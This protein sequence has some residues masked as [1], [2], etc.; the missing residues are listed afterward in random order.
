MDDK[1]LLIIQL[2]TE[3]QQLRKT[4]RQLQE[5]IARLEKNS[6][7]SSKP[8]SSDIIKP[9]RSLKKS[10][11]KKRK[12][13]GQ[14]GHRK[15]SRPTFKPEEI[16]EIIEYEFYAKDGIGLEPLDQWHVVQ[17]I[18]LPEKR[19]LVTEHR[20]R[21]YLDPRTGTIH[22]APLPAEVKQGRLL[23]ADIS[24]MIAFMKG[25]CHMSFS[26]IQQFF[27]EV[28]DLSLSRGVL[29]KATQKVSQSL[30]PMYDSLVERLPDERYLGAD[31]TGHKN[32]GQKYWTWCFPTLN[33][34][35]FHIDK[36]R[37]SKVLFELLGEDFNGILN[38][39]YYGCYRKFARLTDTMVQYCMAH[40]IREIRFLAEHTTKRLARWGQQLLD[41]LKKLFDTLHRCDRMTAVGFAQRMK[42]IKDGFLS[43][44][45]TPPTH[46]LAQTLARRFQ[47]D[48]A[49]TYFR[50]LTDPRVE[51]TNN[52][53]E[54]EIRYTVIDRRITQGTRGDN[55]MR[56]CERIWTV[57]ATCK[58]QKR[59]VFEFIHHSLLAHWNNTSYPKLA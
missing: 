8:P 57:I 41:W 10:S 9:K 2:T 29:N 32:N 45:R 16:D 4:V 19:F 55:G 5:R 31:E 15:F 1:D 39:D 27:N 24:T 51:P 37:G 38:C 50:F 49:E 58:K 40:L 22:I 7:N 35:L 30:K 52:G 20:A 46:R 28:M 56:W 33:Y 11:R 12:R 3:I 59:N 44:I 13:G 18:T 23:G 17:Q 14:P 36:S 26:T 21:K 43:Q 54:R 48:A 34:T 42:A 25:G 47:G 6:N 53:T